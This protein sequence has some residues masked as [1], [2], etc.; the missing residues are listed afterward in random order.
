MPDDSKVKVFTVFQL[1]I[2]GV[3]QVDTNQFIQ[4]SQNRG[5]RELQTEKTQYFKIDSKDYEG[6]TVVINQVS[7]V[8]YSD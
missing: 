2:D 7:Y 1:I 3:D 5:L 4:F 8:F 6:Q